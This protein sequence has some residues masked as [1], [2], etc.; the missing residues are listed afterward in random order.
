MMSAID[1][2]YDEVY[3]KLDDFPG[4]R[5]L[6]FYSHQEGSRFYDASGKS[7]IGYFKDESGG[8]PILEYVDLKPKMYTF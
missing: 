2:D 7:K 6:E 3:L 1:G 8:H 4:R 5:W